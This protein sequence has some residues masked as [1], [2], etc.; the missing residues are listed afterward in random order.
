MQI[1]WWQHTCLFAPS[2]SQPFRLLSLS[3][4]GPQ[5][6]QQRSP[7]HHVGPPQSLPAF[8]FSCLDRI[9]SQQDRQG[10]QSPQSLAG[11]LTLALPQASLSLVNW[12]RDKLIVLSCFPW[13]IV[14]GNPFAHFSVTKYSTPS[15]TCESVP[16][17]G[18][19]KHLLVFCFA[20]Q[21][22]TV[23]IVSPRQKENLYC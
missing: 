23:V 1:K 22:I 8:C 5:E 14:I 12:P 10:S 6:G 21:Y 13:P 16:F 19:V 11:L 4:F 20:K 17:L 3:C 2:R 9:R 15:S 18:F 7:R